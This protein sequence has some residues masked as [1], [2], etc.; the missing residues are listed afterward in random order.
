M[1]DCVLQL[2]NFGYSRMRLARLLSFALFIHRQT[3]LERRNTAAHHIQHWRVFS[4]RQCLIELV[5]GVGLRTGPLAANA[6]SECLCE[7]SKSVAFQPRDGAVARASAWGSSLMA[8]SPSGGGACG[9][10]IACCETAVARCASGAAWRG[11]S[12]GGGGSTVAA[13]AEALVRSVSARLARPGTFHTFRAAASRSKWARAA[14][15][16]PCGAS[17][18]VACGTIIIAARVPATGRHRRKLLRLGKVYDHCLAWRLWRACGG[19]FLPFFGKG[20]FL[21]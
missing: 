16:I 9:D 15:T 3:M 4:V 17:V 8:H 2:L 14:A 1:H 7:A 5:S 18:A 20:H 11:V 21:A 12:A 10:G 13:T 6:A 19:A